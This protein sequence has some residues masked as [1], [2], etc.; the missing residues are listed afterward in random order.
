MLLTFSHSKG[1]LVARDGGAPKGF[2]LSED[3]KKYF[4]AKAVVDGGSVKLS[5]PSVMIP[6]FVRYA[7]DDDPDCDLC[8]KDGLPASPFQAQAQ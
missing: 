1:G 4:W 3:G 2:S 6:K 5:S 8:N 7:W